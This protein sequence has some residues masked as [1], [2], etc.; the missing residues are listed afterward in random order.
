VDPSDLMME[1]ITAFQSEGTGREVFV[2]YSCKMME[3]ASECD[4]RIAKSK[5]KN[6]A[7][8]VS[9]IH[10]TAFLHKCFDLLY[11]V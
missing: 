7:Y 5:T 11:E 6:N 3:W 1:I 4:V 2:R 9:F 8:N 10:I